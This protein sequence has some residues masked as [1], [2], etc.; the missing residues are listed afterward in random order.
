MIAQKLTTNQKDRIRIA[1]PTNDEINI[2]PKM[3]GMARYFLI[4][5]IENSVEFRLIEKRNNPFEKTMQH[6]KTLDVYELIRDCSIII[7]SHIGKKGIKRLQE[8]GMKLIFRKG[9]LQ[10]AII[11]CIKDL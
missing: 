6:L 9:N 11:D 1:T 3:L 4:Y 2:F 7:S 10:E 8:K 5:E